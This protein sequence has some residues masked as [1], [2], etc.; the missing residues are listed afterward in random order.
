MLRVSISESVVPS[1]KGEIVYFYACDM[2]YELRRPEL[3]VLLGKPLVPHQI[4][5]SK[6]SP[7]QQL[8][9][10]PRIARLDP[11]MIPLGE[12]LAECQRTVKVLPIGAVSITLRFPFE[13]AGLEEL[14]G[15]HHSMLAKGVLHDQ[16]KELAEKLRV[17]L[18]PISVRP[19]AKLQEGEDYTVFCVETPKVREGDAPFKG[20]T[21]LQEHRRTIAA[22][23]TL[24]PE[25]ARLS[26]QESMESTSQHL[27][28]YDSDLLVADWD[29]A[30]VV[31][32]AAD[33]E[34]TLY[35]L[36]VANFQLEE[37]IAYDRLLDGALERSYADLLKPAKFFR[38]K[39]LLPHLR[40]VRIDLAR[41]SDE[42]SNITKF[43][44]DWHLARIYETV[45]RR[46]HLADWNR[47]LDDKLKTLDDLYE[48]LK[49]EQ[50]HRLMVV[51][52][53]SIVAMFLLDIVM[54]FAG[55]SK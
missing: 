14:V 50:N 53:G 42:L 46:F 19:V 6:R 28:Y 25:S 40:E 48:M 34:E 30:L 44:G 13:V 5:P 32:R 23:V 24:E 27:S 39:G 52:E 11:V 7:R 21:W 17:E 10:V 15:L 36:E 9:Y 45:A 29:A 26:Q 22:L 37:L 20:E 43:F 54:L 35:V 41:F 31:D 33:F 4:G 12:G 1:L 47:T 55:L 2:A 49:Q 3:N 18:A 51:L 8:L 38:K 16:A